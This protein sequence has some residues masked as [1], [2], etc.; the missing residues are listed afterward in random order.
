MRKNVKNMNNYGSF[1]KRIAALTATLMLLFALTVALLS[2][3]AQAVVA[4]TGGTVAIHVYDPSLGYGELAGWVWLRGGSGTE[5]SIS[6]SAAAG[7]Q[8][9]KDGNAART[10][11]AQFSAAEI[12]QLKAGTQLGFLIC[13]A[14]GGSGDDFWSRYAKETSDVFVD[15]SGSFDADNK[16]DVYY[17]RKDT[18]AYT[19][20]EVAKMALEKI[21]SARFASKTSVEFETSSALTRGANATLYANG[22]AVAQSTLSITDEKGFAGAASFSGFE[23]DFAVDYTLGVDNFP[24]TAPIAKT[25]LIDDV[26][27]IKTYETADTQ[28]LEYGAIYTKDET[29][30]R[31]W[32]PFA[33]SVKVRIFQ[34]GT[35]GEPMYEFELAKRETNG[36]WGGVW[37][38]SVDGDFHKKYYTYLI[39]NN[40]AE[41]ETI[42]PYAKACGANGMRGM[43]VDLS[44]TDPVGWDKDT[45]LYASANEQ[46]RINADVP[47]VW[48]L[49]VKD[50][51]SS[52]D[53]GMVNKGKY[54]AFTETGTTVPGK[55][56]L[57]TGVD[58][59]KD[60]GVTYVHL[61]PVYDFA[62]IDE[63]DMSVADDTKDNFNWGYDPQN[64]NIP[65]GSYSTDPSRGEVRIN[66]F[67]QMVMALHNAGI[68]VIM[69][70]VYNHTY[71]T[72]GQALH[73]TVPYYYHR[74]TETGAFSD[75]SG[76]GNG[77]ASE[78]TMMRK[79]MVDSL[80][81]W[82]TEYH[83]DGFRFDLMGIHDRVT[84]E[85]IRNELDALDGGQGKKILLYGEPWSADGDYTAPSFTKRV[86]ATSAQIGGTGKYTYNGA[87]KMSKHIWMSGSIAEL[88]DRIAIFN[89]NGRD[90]LRGDNNPGQ[91][92][93][94]GDVSKMS[95]VMKMM[96]G[97]CGSSGSGTQMKAG[98]QNVAY[99]SAHDNYPLW[100]QMVG[101]EGGKETPLYYD[102]PM[103]HH[104]NQCKLVSSAYLMSSG[105]VFM[106]AGE[107]IGRTKYGN[108]NSYNSP[109]KL[110][111]IN[112]ARQEQF[113]T[114]HDHYRDL[115]RARVGSPQLF[116]YSKSTEASYCYGSFA[117]HDAATGK[118]VFSRTQGG[119]TLRLTLDAASAS[120]S[121]TI[122]GSTVVRFQ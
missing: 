94:N 114:L 111:Q 17:V 52:P 78:R 12:T 76:C 39:T 121:V 58:Y 4:E 31:V 38:S 79:Y 82:A 35:G 29:T 43:V 9:E 63:G 21:T 23:F 22:E 67:K 50:F 24:K 57:K 32:A 90:G 40:G 10:V 91:G 48:E 101:K 2:S 69:D 51:S 113:K 42:D 28:S 88:P 14:T 18:E 122:G 106:L 5:Y 105:I 49:C 30:F 73:D 109:S 103:D 83:I 65:E 55:S 37:E 26:G 98:S 25:A 71:S 33:S 61:N 119:T 95:G 93:V 1:T 96:E 89:G 92:W 120:G 60:L 102:Y 116:S 19:D 84:L 87:N 64:Y 75:D 70:V 41:V 81:Y 77:T 72:S 104:I 86:S 107:E 45:H 74:T 44:R 62:T 56:T 3:G 13:S 53:S 80:L 6:A 108:H 47:V 54:L 66:E 85:T 7:E 46:Y 36:S 34:K 99:A 59:L 27:F 15:I 115:I 118:L 68:G 97:G 112:W 20:I 16:A 110:N 11:T 100:D 8:F 117:G